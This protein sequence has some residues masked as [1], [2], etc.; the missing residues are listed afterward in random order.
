MACFSAFT[1]RVLTIYRLKPFSQ[2]PAGFSIDIY[3]PEQ[4][5]TRFQVTSAPSSST[6]PEKTRIKYARIR[7]VDAGIR[8]PTASV[9]PDYF[10]SVPVTA[11]VPFIVIVEP[12][13]L[14]VIPESVLPL[15]KILLPLL[16]A[17]VFVVPRVNVYIDGIAK[18]IRKE[19]VG[20]KE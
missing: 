4:V 12:L 1:I 6:Q 19:L 20:K 13:Y 15:G 18:E 14:G 2:S 10:P 16:V 9:E 3:D 17:L 5:A 11:K 8:T 7:L